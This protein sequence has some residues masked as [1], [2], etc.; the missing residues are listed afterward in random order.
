M[1]T[2]LV[3]QVGTVKSVTQ[4]G[5]PRLVIQSRLARE[6]KI[7]DSI[8]VSGVCLT[9]VEVSRDRFAADL[10]GE[11]L[12]RTNLGRLMP[13]S[14][15]NLELPARADSR[16]DG[17]VVQGHVDGTAKLLG[18]ERAEG[19][20]DWRMRIE[21]EDGLEQYVVPQGSITVEGI[22]LTVARI[23]GRIIDIAIIPHTYAATNLRLL[24]VGSPLNF[25]SDV[26]A[27]YGTKLGGKLT[28]EH[29]IAQGF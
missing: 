17:H 20:D 18:L 4:G 2:G 15:V 16:L 26:M 1:F 13:G 19:S 10:A 11:T 29:L 25:E 5:T 21:L 28:L 12:H 6:L 7:G 8:A 3:Q 27:K 24:R 23:S 14:P 22:S 9:A